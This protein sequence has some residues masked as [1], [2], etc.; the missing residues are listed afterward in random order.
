MSDSDAT[1]KDE[2][3]YLVQGIYW[4]NVEF[5]IVREDPSKF[6]KESDGTLMQTQEIKRP[7]MFFSAVLRLLEATN[8]G[9]EFLQELKEWFDQTTRSS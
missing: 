8:Q 4:G 6:A 1:Q 5:D 9:G 3:V 2:R 7:E